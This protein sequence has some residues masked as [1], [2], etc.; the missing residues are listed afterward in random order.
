MQKILFICY[1]QKEKNNKN[2]I[3]PTSADV[4][5]T[6]FAKHLSTSGFN[7]EVL[8]F[9]KY[10]KGIGIIATITRAIGGFFR[11]LKE[12]KHTIFYQQKPGLAGFITWLVCNIKK[13]KLILDIDDYE[14][15]SGFGKFTLQRLLNKCNFI[16]CASDFLCNITKSKT[17]KHVYY[18]PG[19]V[20]TKDIFPILK[21]SKN[22]KPTNK[23]DSAVKLLWL[24]NINQE[25]SLNLIK[26]LDLFKEIRKKD[27]NISL[28]IRGDGTHQ[29]IIE[30]KIKTETITGVKIIGRQKDFNNYLATTDIGIN[31]L[32]DNFYDKSKNPGKTY[33]YLAAGLPIIGTNIGE[34]KKAITHNKNG[35]LVDDDEQFVEYTLKLAKSSKIR[36]EFGKKSRKI[37]LQDFDRMKIVKNLAKILKTELK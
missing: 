7:T 14:F 24:G 26:V 29:N 10:E 6:M 17:N 16:I 18:I 12:P 36:Q 35:F 1:S 13:H 4:R 22:N 20:E 8:N 25:A 23:E 3:M 34:N 21:T 2:N 31:Y 5:C 28:D 32:F 9:N 11:L 37:A 33:T 15:K 19:G 30:N 27:K